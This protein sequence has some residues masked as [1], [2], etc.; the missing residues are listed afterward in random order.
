MTNDK[1]IAAVEISSSK[2]IGAIG[3]VSADGRLNVIAIEKAK[4]LEYVRYG[5]IQNVEET[6]NVLIRIIQQLQSRASISPRTIDAL[7]IG[8][9]GRSMRNI[10]KESIRN[11]GEDSE[12]TDQIIDEIKDEMMQADID[13]SLEIIDAM[14]RTFYVNKAETKLPVGVVGN[15]IRAEFDLIVCRQQ[16]RRNISK[17][18]QEKTHLQIKELI[19]TPLALADMVLS[20]E[21]KRL[22][23]MLVDMGAETTTVSIY[24]DDKLHYLATLPLGSRNITRDITSLNVLEERAEE[25]KTQSGNAMQQETP[26]TLSFN[27]IKLADIN[28]LVVARAE[29][30]VANIIKQ[31]SYAEFEDK[32]LSAGIVVAGGG[33]KLNGLVTLLESQSNMNVRIAKTPDFIILEDTKASALEHAQVISLLYAATKYSDNQCL[34]IPEAPELPEDE[35][36]EPERETPA[37]NKETEP[38]TIVKKKEKTS[39]IREW[40]IRMVSSEDDSDELEEI[41]KK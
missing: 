3:R 4:I 26:S 17:M 9:A 2:V 35:N 31:K 25:L 6:S 18:I 11:L 30:I 8:I 5:I 7:Y 1:Y 41:D 13:N 34:T 15:S 27:G 10:H 24:K 14:P 20:D 38:G 12:I 39:K 40:L 19:I 28:N 32:Q 16:I 23:C 21:E 37:T 22:G 36:Y 33:F 29:E